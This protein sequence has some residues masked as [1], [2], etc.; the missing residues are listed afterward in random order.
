MTDRPVARATLGR[1]PLYLQYL[2]TLPKTEKTISATAIAA[3]LGLGEVQVR[4]DLA[5]VCSAGRPKIGYPIQDLIDILKKHLER[6]ALRQAVIVGAGKLGCALLDFTGF[7]EYGIDITAA[8]DTSPQKTFSPSGKP[9]LPMSE[10]DNYCRLTDIRIGI[11]TVPENAAQEVCD[12]M[13]RC[14]FDAVWNFS[15][16]SLKVPPAVRVRQEN[17]A[18]SFAHLIQ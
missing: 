3:A 17:L 6:D 8:F 5:T 10:F 1:L 13:I 18:L 4:K 9:I 12:R 11:I 7:A 14:G 2:R 15:P 16:C